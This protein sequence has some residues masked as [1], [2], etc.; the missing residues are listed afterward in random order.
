MIVMWI[1]LQIRSAL[2]DGLHRLV[3]L[4]ASV[5]INACL[6]RSAVAIRTPQTQCLVL[7]GR[8]IFSVLANSDWRNQHNECQVSCK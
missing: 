8:E 6:L 4:Q 1:R 2:C 7:V 3:A 5:L